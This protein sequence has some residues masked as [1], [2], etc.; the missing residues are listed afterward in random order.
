MFLTRRFFVKLRARLCKERFLKAEIP[1]PFFVARLL[2]EIS[3][4]IIIGAGG[5]NGEETRSRR[6]EIPG[7]ALIAGD[8]RD[9]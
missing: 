3:I 6:N 2:A 7:R 9:D 8:E 1:F 4:T 5:K